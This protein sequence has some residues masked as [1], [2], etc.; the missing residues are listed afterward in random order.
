MYSEVIKKRNFV[1]RNVPIG[2]ELNTI[3]IYNI[4]P[5]LYLFRKMQYGFVQYTSP[6]ENTICLPTF[7][8]LTCIIC[9]YI[10][11]LIV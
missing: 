5:R 6:G 8:C 2:Y 1:F 7:Q 11:L 3:R 4:A 9:M 10:L